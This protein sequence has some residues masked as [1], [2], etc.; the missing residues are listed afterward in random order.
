MIPVILASVLVTIGSVDL[1]AC[2]TAVCIRVRE[3]GN[4]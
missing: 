4:V 3:F 1:V 2:Y